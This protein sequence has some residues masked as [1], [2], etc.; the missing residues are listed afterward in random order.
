MNKQCNASQLTQQRLRQRLMF[1]ALCVFISGFVFTGCQSDPPQPAPQASRPKTPDVVN[2]ANNKK[3]SDNVVASLRAIRNAQNS[4]FG[5]TGG[6][7]GT[8]DYL[9]RNQLLPR[10][11]A[12]EKPTVMGYIF[13]LKF[14]QISAD[15]D[16]GGAYTINADP[17]SGKGLHFFMDKEHVIH[18]RDKQAAT[19]SDPVFEEK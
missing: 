1:I 10:N 14:G 16:T 5:R 12:G 19:E 2:V 13:T 4:C 7:Y 15:Y 8:F 17:A 18:Y 11:F 3:D 9:T 6:R